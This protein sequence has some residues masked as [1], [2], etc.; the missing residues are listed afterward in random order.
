MDQ[1]ALHVAAGKPVR[2]HQAE[3]YRAR[4]RSLGPA[5]VQRH[6]RDLPE[7]LYG[8]LSRPRVVGEGEAMS[9][10]VEMDMAKCTGL[11]ICEAL[12]PDF[13]EVGDDGVLTVLRADVDPSDLAAVREA[14]E[15]CP[16]EALKL[17]S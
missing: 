3:R 13:F 15:S 6:P 10:R 1:H 7:P 11:G 14:V 17:I 5:R 4:E 9:A 12:A 2:R 8:S 16:T